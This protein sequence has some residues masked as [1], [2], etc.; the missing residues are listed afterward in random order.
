[1]EIRVDGLLK[2]FKDADHELVV[3][4]HVFKMAPGSNWRWKWDEDQESGSRQPSMRAPL[5]A[6][7]EPE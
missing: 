4:D 2:S 6:L 5:F 7:A 1:M 3:M